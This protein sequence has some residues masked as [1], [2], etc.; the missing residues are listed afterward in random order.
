MSVYPLI[1]EPILKPRIWG[2]RQ[3]ADVLGK[4]LPPG[5]PIGESW[6]LADLP[7]N[8]SL[9]REGP[10]R[11]W[12]IRRIM[13]QWGRDLLGTVQPIRGRFPLL[14]K[15]LDASRDL[16]VQVHP[17]PA[18]AAA[19]ANA[20]PKDEAWYVIAAQPGAIIYHGL[21]EGVTR[22]RVLEALAR[23]EVASLLR[24]VPARPGDCFWLPAGT[25]HA[26]GA[27]LL[28]TEVQTPSDT[29]YRLFDWNR[30]D[31]ST[32]RPRELHVEQALRSINFEAP[33]PP[34]RQD[35]THVAS[36]WTTV[37]RLVT[38][39]RFVLDQVRM[40]E[41][42]EQSIP[43]A[44]PVVWIVLEGAAE[45]GYAGGVATARRGDVV[46]LPA[47][48]EKARMRAVERCVW[49]EV[50]IPSPGDLIGYGGQPPE[51]P[52][53]PGKVPAPEGSPSQPRA[54]A[55]PQE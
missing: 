32:G 16:S 21:N 2:G 13:E 1:F 3:L 31:E 49:L 9:V 55:P 22:G 10:A 25:V 52:A 8:E 40:A 27:G 35:R 29:T 46:L 45:I 5:E 50:R 7:G 23:G 41:G 54:S 44:E 51:R 4:P 42:A 14:V 53:S 12:S 48:L 18:A 24:R 38:C 26:L 20:D 6:E 30:V 19:E 43:Y 33:G 17:S 37:T 34:P 11:G 28:V 47:A 36:L 15:F 39:D